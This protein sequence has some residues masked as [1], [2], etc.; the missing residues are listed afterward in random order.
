MQQ[1]ERG[2]ALNRWR[3]MQDGEFDQLR[4]HAR[5]RSRVGDCDLT[6]LCAATET[7]TEL[8]EMGIDAPQA[9]QLCG[10]AL[11]QGYRAR[12]IRELAWM[13]GEAQRNGAEGSE[14]CD[15]L[16]QHIRDR[17]HLGDM[18]QQMQHEG[19]MGPESM[20]GGHGGHSPVDEVMGGGH[21]GDGDGG[22]GG[23]GGG[24]HGDGGGMGG[25]GGMGGS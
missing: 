5:E 11:Q 13:V 20:G 23:H 16:Q 2:V 15:Q 10:E 8:R 14:V 1:L 4:D 19:W 18:V 21:H 9:T 3:G 22:M 24:G 17:E 7:T 6:D 25:E 12:E